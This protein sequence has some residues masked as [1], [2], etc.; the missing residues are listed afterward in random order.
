[1]VFPAI[2]GVEKSVG[3]K[4][5]LGSDFM[6]EITNKCLR[7]GEKVNHIFTSLSGKCSILRFVCSRSLAGTRDNDGKTGVRRVK[8]WI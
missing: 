6:K 2:S 1:M 7:K 4:A 5:N 3:G 8:L